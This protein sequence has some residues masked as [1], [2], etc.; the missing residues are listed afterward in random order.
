M[1]FLFA[2]PAPPYPLNLTVQEEPAVTTVVAPR[3]D[4]PLTSTS[5]GRVVVSGEELAETGERSLPRAIS[6]AAGVWL[7]E[8][9]LGGGAPFLRG[10]TGNQVLVVID[11]VRLNDSTTR[12]GPNQSLNTIDIAIVE[13]VEVLL[14]PSSVLYGSDAIGGTIL[15]WTKARR[16]GLRGGST[17]PGVQ[18]EVDLHGETVTEGGRAALGLSHASER[19]GTLVVGS[20][21]D[22]DDLHTSGNETVENTGYHGNDF[23]ASEEVAIDEDRSLRATARVHRDFDV[24]RTDRM[25]PGFGQTNP[26]NDAYIFRLQERETFQLTYDDAQDNGL[27]DQFQVRLAAST[28]EEDRELIGFG[29]TTQRL[30]TDEVETYSIGVDW[31]RAL[32][33]S[34]LLTW[35]LDFYQDDVDSS[36]RDVDLTTGVATPNEGTFAPNSEYASFGAFVQDE[37]VAFDA[38]DV[39]AGLRYSHF[40]FSFDNFA[41]QGGGEEDG[42]FG[43]LTA[44]LQVARDLSEDVRLTGGIAQGFRAPNLDDLAKD[45]TFAGG[46]ELHNADLDPEKSLTEELTLEF[47]RPTYQIAGTIFATQISDLVGRRLVAAGAPPPGDETYLR[48]NVGDADQFGFELAYRQALGGEHSGLGLECDLAWVYSELDD[49]TV[50]PV[51]GEETFD[52][53]PIQRTPPLHGRVGLRYE[54][55][56]R[57]LG[58]VHWAQVET[59][60]AAEQSRLNPNDE[61]DPRIDPDGTDGWYVVNLDVGGPIGDPARAS[62]WTLG[63]HNAFD[64]EYRVHGSGFDG[65]G[66]GLVAG[67]HLAF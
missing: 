21:Q 48:D 54:P 10:L 56:E 42:D 3:S 37:I 65:P 43:A 22:W 4:R 41:S 1:P 63:L 36:R 34:H 27:W 47:V 66:I 57:W 58:A 20:G 59:V 55:A 11:G 67:L 14:G 28:Y 16:P 33:E 45:G 9:N 18:A 39:T 35:G 26:S 50:D 32:G 62:T 64:Y 23:F 19:S 2:S 38:F 51:T 30:E 40:D 12:F 17:D 29:S 8:T 61:S 46:T 53:E 7:Q 44:S 5:T 31:R 49:D 6:R 52:G 15:I 60:F 25:N 13:R 24:P